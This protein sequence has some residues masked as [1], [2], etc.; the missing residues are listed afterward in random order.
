MNDQ[1]KMLTQDIKVKILELM[2]DTKAAI[3]KA[4]ES[5]EDLGRFEVIISTADQDRA[6]EIIELSA[7]DLSLYKMNPVVLWA[8]DYAQLPIGAA[9][10][11]E[12]KDGNLVAT[13]TFA[14]HEFAQTVRRLY[15][16]KMLRATSVG[17]IPR[18][19]VGNKITEAE[20]LEFSFVPVPANPYA[21]S[22]AKSAL[23]SE[24][25]LITKGFM[26]KAEVEPAPVEPQP[27]K[28][29]EP[30]PEPE[31]IV[32]PETVA[33]PIEPVE[34]AIEPEPVQEP[35]PE[36]PEGDEATVEPEPEPETIEKGMVADEL[37]F[38][39]AN[40]AAKWL[41]LDTIEPIIYT[42][43]D[44]F[45][46]NSVK[47]EQ[48][49]E[50]AGEMVQLLTAAITGTETTEKGMIADEVTLE[51]TAQAALIIRDAMIVA[52]TKA[53][54]TL[55]EKNRTLITDCVANMENTCTALKNLLETAD[56]EKGGAP[57][58]SQV[59]KV[60]TAEGMDVIKNFDEFLVS[61]RFLRDVATATTKALETINARGKKSK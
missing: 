8:H 32:E 53:G 27:E 48:F 10:T 25:A 4:Q 11:V 58:N 19:M 42:F 36:K 14:P 9:D 23:I 18:K 37:E 49:G 6:G 13:G 59:K 50:L 17:L 57:A 55:S 61:K 29:E 34:P 1:F 45:L 3:A 41:C 44:V 54:K 22:L 31:P 24:D 43:Y 52:R 30:T 28:I 40:N 20:L 56:A 2:A 12:V 7:W 26:L 47:A 5:G 38:D 21:L 46:R 35:E 39:R 51:K 16:L 60:E 33:D 15:D